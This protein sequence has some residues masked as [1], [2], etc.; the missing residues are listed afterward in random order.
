MGTLFEQSPRGRY[1][2]T[3]RHLLLA[4][5]EIQNVSDK[6]GLTINQV[7][8]IRKILEEERKNNISVSNGDVFDEQMAGFGELIQKF[9]D[10]E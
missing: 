4:A 8:E 1:L 10:K 7:I 9:I 6:T 5:E 3:E 2:I